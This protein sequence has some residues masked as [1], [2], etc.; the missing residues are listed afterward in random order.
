VLPIVFADVT[1]IVK[2]LMNTV[3]SKCQNFV[4]QDVRGGASFGESHD[5]RPDV[6][7]A[8]EGS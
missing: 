4:M 2:V 8:H 6:V 3:K 5:V 1:R 7:C